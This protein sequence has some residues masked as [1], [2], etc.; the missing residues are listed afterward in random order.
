MF[1]YVAGVWA[2]LQLLDVLAG[3]WSVSLQFQQGFSVVLGLA[4]FPAFVLAWYH[5]EKGRQKV[6]RAE[7]ALLTG[8]LVGS[9]L[10][11][12]MVFGGMRAW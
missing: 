5:G 1:S 10:V 7:L 4:A 9:F 12:S 8:S 6:C 3:I 11:L 2:L